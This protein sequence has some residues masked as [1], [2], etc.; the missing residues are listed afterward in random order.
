MHHLSFQSDKLGFPDISV[1]SFGGY[2]LD[3]E[4]LKTKVGAIDHVIE[5]RM[6]IL[7]ETG[8]EIIFGTAT[9]RC[10]IPLFHHKYT[11]VH[12]WPEETEL[13]WCQPKQCQ[14]TSVGYVTPHL[15]PDGKSPCA[16]RD[17]DDNTSILFDWDCLN[18]TV[19][20][21][22]FQYFILTRVFQEYEYWTTLIRTKF[23]S[24]FEDA[25][26]S[27]TDGETFCEHIGATLP[28]FVS[29]GD[30]NEFCLVMNSYLLDSVDRR[31]IQAAFIGLYR[32]NW[33]RNLSW[34]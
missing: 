4:L 22:T 20:A 24:Y 3:R 5:Q 2:K 33:V 30:Y 13:I 23:A 9:T 21:T 28:Y 1:G 34:R 26:V 15:K 19:H 14:R 10:Q 17:A 32:D 27:W 31:M 8:A 18:L 11:F 29:R 6:E 16:G 25:Q 7:K 12:S